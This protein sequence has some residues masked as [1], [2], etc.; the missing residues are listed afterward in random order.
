MPLFAAADADRERYSFARSASLSMGSCGISISPVRDEDL[1]LW[2]CGVGLAGD[3]AGKEQTATVLLLPEELGKNP[4]R[5]AVRIS[6]CEPMFF[7]PTNF[8]QFSFDF[9]EF[10]YNGTRGNVEENVGWKYCSRVQI[11]NMYTLQSCIIFESL[12][13]MENFNLLQST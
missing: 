11:L 7:N 3:V 8:R 12:R 4:F 6:P 13:H 5:V 10:L 2:T 1:G 9:V